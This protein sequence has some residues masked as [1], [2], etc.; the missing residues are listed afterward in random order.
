M[1]YY[2]ANPIK[3]LMSDYRLFNQQQKP[4]YTRKCSVSLLY[5]NSIVD[6]GIYQRVLL[7]LKASI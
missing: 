7:L 5:H 1:F 6:D 4:Q 2:P 3:C